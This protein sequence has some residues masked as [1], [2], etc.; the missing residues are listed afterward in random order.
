MADKEQVLI[1]GAGPTGLVA[2]CTLLRHGIRPRLIDARPRAFGHSKALLLWP[3]SMDVL[4]QL[5]LTG[6]VAER[7][8]PLDRFAYYSSK[9]HVASLRF[10]EGTRPL[11]LPQ[12]STEEVLTGLLHS[13]GGTV[14]RGLRLTS[15]AE[16]HDGVVAEAETE[17]GDRHT[18]QAEWVIGA[19]GAHSAVRGLL[20]IE[21]TGATY[22]DTFMLADAF[23]GEHLRRDVAHYFQ[24]PGGVL[25]VVPLPDGRHRFFVNAPAG[26]TTGSLELL[27]R[28]TEER[29]PGGVTL[30]D[31]QWISTF[32]VHHRVVTRMRGARCFLAGDAAHIHSPAGG[33][34][35]NTG[36]QDAHNLAWKLAAVLKGR[37]LPRLLGTYQRERH[38]VA[39]Q[40]V[41]DTDI[42]T[43]AWLVSAP[44]KVRV[45]DALLR[46]AHA[47][48]ALQRYAPVMAGR[49][50][51]YP[52][53]LPGHPGRGGGARSH[54]GVGTTFPVA[55]PPRGPDVPE[56]PVYRLVTVCA[57]TDPLAERGEEVAAR[58]AGLVRHEV[59]PPGDR[60]TPRL[61]CG[62]EGYYLVRPDGYIAR[63]GHRE[64]IGAVQA[65]LDAF[66][67]MPS[68]PGIPSP[69]A[70]EE[71]P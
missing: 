64:D 54:G 39:R 48:G 32:Q 16:H 25:V 11:C 70:T 43:R 55:P 23:G 41:R 4:A 60:G 33:Q 66:H 67:P 68:S 51:S 71:G 58:W 15:L 57:P 56:P 3:R 22:P 17:S 63:H 28:L 29:G 13:L 52:A 40:V 38:S 1:V 44:W 2:A 47:T 26:H 19:D 30:T 12:R 49:R 20:G 7:S 37:A 69:T 61:R 42:Q 27:Q 18:L 50:I 36:L 65:L 21:F 31:P 35:L 46:A 34:G 8:L 6:E 9:R 62:R 45:R 59:L 24:S 14:E 53:M 5:D 10:G